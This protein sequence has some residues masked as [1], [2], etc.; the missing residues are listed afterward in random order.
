[1]SELIGDPEQYSEQC[2]AIIID[3]FDE[4]GLLNEAAQFNQM[5]GASASL[6]HPLP[7][8]VARLSALKPILHYGQMPALRL[9]RP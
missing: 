8:V 4:A 9:T 3:Q 7:P 5:P 2:G 6:L 1:M